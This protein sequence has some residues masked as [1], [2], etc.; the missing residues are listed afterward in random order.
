MGKRERKA[1]SFLSVHEKRFRR[2]IERNIQK[3]TELKEG[4]SGARKE[5]KPAKATGNE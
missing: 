4:E 3:L 5:Y 1:R 2:Q